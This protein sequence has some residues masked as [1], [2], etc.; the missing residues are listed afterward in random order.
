MHGR[1]SSTIDNYW[2]YQECMSSPLFKFVLSNSSACEQCH[3]IQSRSSER[4]LV[5][6]NRNSSEFSFIASPIFIVCDCISTPNLK[7]ILMCLSVFMDIQFAP[8]DDP[9]S[10]AC[11]DS[12]ALVYRPSPLSNEQARI[13]LHSIRSRLSTETGGQIPPI[14]GQLSEH[15]L[16]QTKAIF[17]QCLSDYKD[18]LISTKEPGSS[19]LVWIVY[20]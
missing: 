10:P 12:I 15:F 20:W 11:S 17:C 9:Y 8:E 5:Y 16:F 3:Y 7:N 4:S 18:K 6:L 2:A 19:R 13:F 1:R 14:R